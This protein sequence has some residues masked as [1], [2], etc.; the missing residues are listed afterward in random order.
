VNDAART[1]AQAGAVLLGGTLRQWSALHGGDLSQVVRIVLADGRTAVVKGGPSPRTEASMLTAIAASGAPAPHVLAA[2]DSA[3][4]LQELTTGGALAEAWRSLGKSLARLHAVRCARYGWATTYS[5]GPVAIENA[6]CDDWT[7]FWAA[8]RLLV[9]VP[10]VSAPIAR[11]VAAL[12]SDLPN[13]LP[14][15]PPASLLHGDLWSGNVLASRGAVTGLIDPACYFG[16]GEVDIAMLG[17]FD[18]PDAAF[19]D[20]YGALEAGSE[21]RLTI[22]RLWP[23]LVHLRLFGDGYRPLVEGLL[24]AAR[25]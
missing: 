18:R 22:Y 25:V 1:L 17:L 13:R 19:F 20:A 16:H 12:A 21:A 2:S 11:R 5:F 8:R 23:A 4:V 6:W 9:H 7:D 24:A 3:L 10:H 14:R 15:Q